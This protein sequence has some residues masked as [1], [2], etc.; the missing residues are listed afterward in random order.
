MDMQLSVEYELV[1]QYGTTNPLIADIDIV[2]QNGKLITFN[3][4]E[5]LLRNINSELG[6]VQTNIK[7]MPT[8][9][10]DVFTPFSELSG[11]I[12]DDIQLQEDSFR[13]FLI[14]GDNVVLYTIKIQTQHKI[15][16]F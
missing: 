16:S 3:V 5:I 14:G 1:L 15:L 12:M 8:S 4:K 2:F 10:P 7:L 9:S 11:I 6:Q 13:T